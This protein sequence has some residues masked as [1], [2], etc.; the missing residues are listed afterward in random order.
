LAKAFSKKPRTHPYLLSI[1][2]LQNA[3]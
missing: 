3:K 2:K 1:Q